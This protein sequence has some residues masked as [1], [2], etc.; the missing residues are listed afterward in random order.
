MALTK[1]TSNDARDMTTQKPPEKR[2]GGR[3]RN[4]EKKSF[5]E[6]IALTQTLIFRN[7][8]EEEFQPERQCPEL[9]QTVLSAGN[10]EE[11]AVKFALGD[12]G[13]E[14]CD[15]LG[16]EDTGTQVPPGPIPPTVRATQYGC[17]I[18]GLARS[19]PEIISTFPELEEQP[20]DFEEAGDHY[21][22]EPNLWVQEPAARAAGDEPA[23]QAIEEVAAEA[24]AEEVIR[25]IMASEDECHCDIWNKEDN[26]FDEEEEKRRRK[27][28][29]RS[30][31]SG[32]RSSSLQCHLK[33]NLRSTKCRD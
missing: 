32:P 27:E 3:N 6:M 4:L 11:E 33:L 15:N 24:T 25:Q 9:E 16:F 23:A 31:G 7:L 12:Y 19:L 17:H 26:I 30:T 18:P 22:P 28:K 1:N 10:C 14:D 5:L 8:Q 29:P 20:L 13:Q 2:R 21:L